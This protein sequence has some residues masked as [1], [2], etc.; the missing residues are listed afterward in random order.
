[1]QAQTVGKAD[2]ASIASGLSDFAQGRFAEAL[3][4][5]QAASNA[6]SATAS[7]YLGVMYDTG[8]GVPQ[9]YAEALSWYKRAGEA[10]SGP[11]LFNAGVMYDSGRGAAIDR[12]EAARW[13]ARAAAMGFPRAE[14]NLALMY[15]AG[16]GVTRDPQRATAL[17]RAAAGH[18]LT[19]AGTHFKQR[20]AGPVHPVIDAATQDFQKAQLSLLARGAS[21]AS[22]AAELFH[23]A[24]EQHNALAEYDYG[25][26]LENGLGVPKDKP[27]AYTWYRRAVADAKDPNLHAIAQSGAGALEIQLSQAQLDTARRVLAGK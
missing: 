18:G 24:A 8:Q 12:A 20:F 2:D 5:W 26:C 7:L 17:F 25:Y 16:D 15:E 23:H 21:E 11:G 6:G 14:Y 3:Q 10:G 22:E 27:M 1:M 4:S 9:S 19:A 13:Y